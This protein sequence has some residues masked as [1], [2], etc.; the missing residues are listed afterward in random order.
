MQVLPWAGKTFQ[1]IGGKHYCLNSW[2]QSYLE[3]S[4]WGNPD[5]IIQSLITKP[6][7]FLQLKS[8]HYLGSPSS[9]QTQPTRWWTLTAGKKLQI[10]DQ[11]FI[12]HA[13]QDL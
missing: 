2:G 13:L 7:L 4:V 1:M 9:K 11:A 6:T 5:Q 3:T 10:G 12:H 8:E